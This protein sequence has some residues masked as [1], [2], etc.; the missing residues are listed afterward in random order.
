METTF[1]L[2]LETDI[3][4]LERI[5]PNG[6]VLAH[7]RHR[8]DILAIERALTPLGAFV[9]NEVQRGW[10]PATLGLA[11]IDALL[12]LLAGQPDLL[13]DRDTIIKEL[14]TLAEELMLAEQAGVRFHFVA[15]L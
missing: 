8:L 13:P 12:M 10:F 14:T 5:R 2:V 3:L 7:Y 15:W 1:S 9:S 11:T 4:P 6:P